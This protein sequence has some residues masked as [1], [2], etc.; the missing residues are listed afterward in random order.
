ML[1]QEG[2]A[3]MDDHRRRKE[4]QAVRLREE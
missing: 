1:E 2:H 4:A 3:A